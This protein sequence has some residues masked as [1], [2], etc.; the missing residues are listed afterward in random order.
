MT[1]SERDPARLVTLARL[2]GSDSKEAPAGALLRAFPTLSEP[3]DDAVRRVKARVMIQISP[4]RRRHH[5]AW[6]AALIILA[7]STAGATL[8]LRV[9]RSS[10]KNTSPPA[11]PVRTVPPTPSDQ[12]ARLAIPAVEP[13][14]VRSQAAAPPR[15][16]ATHSLTAAPR[17][18]RSLPAPRAP[19][20]QPDDP[21]LEEARLLS[22][23]LRKV[24]TDRD[25]AGALA[26]LDKSKVAPRVLVDETALARV[27]AL[28]L[29]G[30]KTEALRVLEAHSVGV[31][32]QRRQI[33]VVRGEL[34]A[35]LDQCGDAV[36][37]FTQV[38]GVRPGEDELA[39]R[40]LF[41]RASCR[42]R[43]GLRSAA[44]ADLREYLQRFPE[45]RFVGAARA[46]IEAK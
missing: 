16:T 41:G 32:S 14:I 4:K 38:L 40:S 35:D 25:P 31:P 45:G 3:T 29:L 44:Q 17:S 2:Q 33:A 37:R 28:L 11:R 6:A 43:L 26:L 21:A 42:A 12:G 8:G 19:S 24:R 7:A 18:S 46:A 9:F 1:N 15:S 36:T 27:E 22:A 39:E 23:A 13:P 10:S 5:L 20:V 34:A 30:R